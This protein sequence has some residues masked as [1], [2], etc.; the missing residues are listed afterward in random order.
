MKLSPIAKVI[1]LFV[2][3]GTLGCVSSSGNLQRCDETDLI[4]LMLQEKGLTRE[5]ARLDAASLDALAAQQKMVQSH[6]LRY[7]K[8]PYKFPEFVYGV[9]DE[10]MKRCQ[11]KK[12]G[13]FELFGWSQIRNGSRAAIRFRFI[14]ELE[15]DKEQPIQEA[16]AKLAKECNVPLENYNNMVLAKAIKNVPHEVQVQIAKFILGAREAKYYRDRA[17][18][19]Y[20]QERLQHAFDCAIENFTVSDKDETKE[21]E[22]KEIVH[23]DLG[24][25]LDYDDLYTGASINIKVIV[26]LEEFLKQPQT[27]QEESIDLTQI[28]FEFNTPL[29]KVAFNGK[30]EDNTYQGEDYLVIIDLAGNDTYQGA[31]AS[32]YKLEH[33]IST[34]ID[35]SGNDTYVADVKTPCAQ[36]AGVLGYGFLVDNDGDD[37]FTAVN[38]AQGMGYFGVGILWARGGNDKFKGHTSVQGS[39]AF[40]IANLVKIDGNDDY[41]A[42]FTSQGFGYVGGYGCLIDTGGDDKYVAEPY[43]LVHPAKG[44]HDNL[45]NYSFCQGAGWGQRGDIFGGHS[46]GGG[47]GILQD[48]GG[49][50]HYECGVYGQATGYWYGTGILHDQAG[51]D[52]YEGSFF[53]QSGTAHMGLTMLLD[54]AGDDTYHV[55]HAI[56]QAGAHDFSVSYLIDKGGNDKFSAWEWKDK[57]NKQTLT[58][59]DTKGSGGGTLIGSAINNSVAIF[60]NIGGNDTYEYYTK[61]CFGWSATRA[62]VGSFRYKNFNIAMFIDV[63]GEDDYQI[64]ITDKLPEG[65]RT[66][67]NNSTWMRASYKSGNKDKVFSSAIDTEKGIILESK[68]R[69]KK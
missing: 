29:G 19:N 17:V 35:W 3:I 22:D 40:G 26:D 30:D 66:I 24:Q 11:H 37:T 39:A 57:E 20:P 69:L 65:W 7:W 64:K 18:R 54:E 53:V 67:G 15:P 2:L 56:S 27:E 44:G 6:F 52:H 55:W 68:N 4:G 23:W 51:D 34:I 36:G 63:R 14:P 32:S 13:M 45:R 43:D 1:T 12:R 25:A 47:T 16:L 58:P 59:T 60:M 41:Y 33:P 38:N 5:T 21:I 10:Q 62:D 49:N 9:L 46:M 48:L 28:S 61:D 31:A 50:D 42:Y 8:D